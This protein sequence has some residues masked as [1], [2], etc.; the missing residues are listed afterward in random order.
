[1]TRAEELQKKAGLIDD[2]FDIGKIEEGRLAIQ[3]A[4]EA[5]KE[6]DRILLKRGTDMRIFKELKEALRQKM[7]PYQVVPEQ[8]L[9]FI[10]PARNHQGV[11]AFVSSVIYQPIEE[12]VQR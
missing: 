1:M 5:N 11:I 2:L 4:L 9:D 8:K 12:I 6:I 10:C 7:I 3:E